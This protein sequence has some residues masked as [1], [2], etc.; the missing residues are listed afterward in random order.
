MATIS[1]Y[2]DSTTTR[3]EEQHDQDV[4]DVRTRTITLSIKQQIHQLPVCLT[5]VICKYQVA[6]TPS[7]RKAV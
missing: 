7:M 3:P 4:L 2:N 5:E 6:V 1:T